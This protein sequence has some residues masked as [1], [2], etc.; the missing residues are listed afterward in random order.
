MVPRSTRP[1]TPFPLLSSRTSRPLPSYLRHYTSNTSSSSRSLRPSTDTSCHRP[2]TRSQ[3]H[4]LS[5]SKWILAIAAMLNV[6]YWIIFSLFES[7]FKIKPLFLTAG[8]LQKE[9]HTSHTDCDLAMSL[10]PRFMSL[11]SRWCSSH[12]TWLRVQTG[13]QR[14]KY[15]HCKL[16]SD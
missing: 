9:S 14:Y 16:C 8:A 1:S 7:V 5:H 6:L 11:H 12:A 2:G 10:H 15:P 3:I 4:L 13:K